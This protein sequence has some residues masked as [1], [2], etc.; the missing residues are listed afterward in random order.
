MVIGYLHLCQRRGVIGRSMHAVPGYAI[1]M[2]RSRG[3]R[4]HAGILHN[5]ILQKA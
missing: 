2:K 5:F 4:K 1:V 3:Q